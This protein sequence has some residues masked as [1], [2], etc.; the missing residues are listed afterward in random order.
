MVIAWHI[1]KVCLSIHAFGTA[2]GGVSSEVYFH[3]TTTFTTV[4]SWIA[5]TASNALK[6]G[7]ELVRYLS[8][9]TTSYACSLAIL[10]DIC[11]SKIP[12]MPTL[13][14]AEMVQAAANDFAIAVER[15]VNLRSM[16]L[17][18]VVFETEIQSLEISLK[19]EQYQPDLL[20]KMGEFSTRV[21]TLSESLGEFVAS[22]SAS[23]GIMLMVTESLNNTLA[24]MDEKESRSGL[25]VYI[26]RLFYKLFGLNL[27]GSLP[28]RLVQAYER[29]LNILEQEND[30]QLSKSQQILAQC[31]DLG[32]RLREIRYAIGLAHEDDKN[33]KTDLSE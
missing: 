25:W 11:T 17:N 29:W 15:N 10:K 18:L 13:F 28:D 4:G 19:I 9:T 7:G 1:F 31:E 22:N 16:S 14:I 3:L 21:P 8:S 26:G 23:S 20:Q 2:L 12:P 33:S 27:L 32:G 5:G 24:G 30:L 6:S